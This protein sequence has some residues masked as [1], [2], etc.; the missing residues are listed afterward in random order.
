LCLG[1]RPRR[2]QSGDRD[3]QLGITKAGNVYLR[4]L[5]VETRQT[6]PVQDLHTVGGKRG[7]VGADIQ[8]RRST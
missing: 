1:L 3:P 8:A 6:F 2:S 7:L 5:L 4:G